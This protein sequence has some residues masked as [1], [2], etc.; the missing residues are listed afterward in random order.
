MSKNLPGHCWQ[1]T[2]MHM[3]CL[4]TCGP[5]DN[6][7]K[8]AHKESRQGIIYHNILIWQTRTYTSWLNLVKL[9]DDKRWA[10]HGRLCK[11]RLGYLEH[12]WQYRDSG[13][14]HTNAIRPW[15]TKTS[16]ILIGWER[17][18][19]S[20]TSGVRGGSFGLQPS[21]PF[22][23]NEKSTWNLTWQVWIMLVMIVRNFSGR[24]L[25]VGLTGFAAGIRVHT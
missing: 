21:T 6:K 8:T 12:L 10:T 16:W 25:K 13:Q 3:E 5:L 7:S 1:C 14:V 24:L 22:S 2:L 20:P 23:T 11:L 18:S 4:F 15:L 9:K 19:W 17:V